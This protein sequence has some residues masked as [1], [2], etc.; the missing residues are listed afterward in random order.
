[1]LPWGSS[2]PSK[3]CHL[4]NEEPEALDN[5]GK[6]TKVQR[7][8]MIL[9]AVL[10]A[11]KYRTG[12]LTQSAVGRE[13]FQGRGYEK[14]KS[15]KMIRKYLVWRVR[16]SFQVKVVHLQKG[17]AALWG[18]TSCP[19][20]E[21]WKQAWSKWSSAWASCSVSLCLYIPISRT[22]WLWTLRAKRATSLSRTCSIH[23]SYRYPEHWLP[24]QSIIIISHP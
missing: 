8:V 2:L 19:E 9:S 16:K 5:G 23:L 20:A 3:S 10:W 17:T 6:N 15:W 18:M 24:P 7:S 11:E 12:H 4:E 14:V 13:G 22:T 1:M 21:K